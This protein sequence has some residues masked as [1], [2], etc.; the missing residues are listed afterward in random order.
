MTSKTMAEAAPL[1]A[2]PRDYNAAVDLI[3]RNL[4]AGRA[5]K[6]AVRDDR[7]AYSY[8]ELA[9]R[10]ERFADLVTRLGVAPEQRILLCLLDGID[11]PTV[12]LGAITAGVVPVP[13]NTL[14]TAADYDF[15]LRDSRAR[16]LVVSQPLLAGLAP[17]IARH[18]GLMVIV[19][20]DDGGDHPRL[21][22]L[23]AEA[24]S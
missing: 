17:V 15:M 14:L 8:G 10:V 19:A 9:E 11:F 24:T 2:L 13:V 16:V 3:S 23:M 18:P 7:G 21:A 20:G 1:A 4:A 22:D 6:I 12:F 5:G